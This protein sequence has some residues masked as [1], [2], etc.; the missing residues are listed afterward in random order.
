MDYTKEVIFRDFDEAAEYY[1]RMGFVQTD[2][3]RLILN[4]TAE[5]EI[6]LRKLGPTMLRSEVSIKKSK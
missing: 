5:V 4:Y 6:K 3:K 2:D 1:E